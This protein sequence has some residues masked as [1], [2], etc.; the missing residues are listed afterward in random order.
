MDNYVDSDGCSWDD[1]RSRYLMGELGFCGCSD[2]YLGDLA[3]KITNELYTAK[4]TNNDWFYEY[5]DKS[6][7]FLALQECILLLME[8]E[9]LIEHGTSIRGS[10][11]TDK[12][13]D[14]IKKT[15]EGNI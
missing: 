10:W 2:D 5:K 4:T 15:I 14:V 1:A 13:L 9:K 11:L 3:W 8:K 6:D 7:D 12:G